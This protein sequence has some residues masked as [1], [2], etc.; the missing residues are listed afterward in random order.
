MVNLRKGIS[1]VIATVIIVAVAV[2]ISIAVVGWIM[3]LWSTIAGG[4]EQLQVYPNVSLYSV[5]DGS[6]LNITVY[7]RGTA[8]SIIIQV[9][10][11]GLDKSSSFC[12][13][14]TSDI[15]TCNKAQITVNPGN[16]TSFTVKFGKHCTPGAQYI[17]KV[18]TKAGNVYQTSAICEQA[19]ST[20]S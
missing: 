2:A 1:P 8:S 13:K 16:T 14:P 3:G 15:S 4:T 18:Y 19:P 12:S 11:V 7:N 17:I 6:A 9:E 5:S 10:I 20:S